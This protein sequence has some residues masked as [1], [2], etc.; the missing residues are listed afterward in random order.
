MILARIEWS[1]YLLGYFINDN[2]MIDYS[3]FLQMIT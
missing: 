2:L 1:M 3:A